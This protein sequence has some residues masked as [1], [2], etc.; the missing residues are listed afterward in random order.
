M[1]EYS[2]ELVKEEL[3]NLKNL[4]SKAESIFAL[5]AT[6]FYQGFHL[7]PDISFVTTAMVFEEISHIQSKLS[8]L[9]SLMLNNRIKIVEPSKNTIKLVQ[10]AAKHMG[11][12][13][14]TAADIS[15]IALAKDKH[16]ILVTDDFAICN[17]ANTMSIALLNLG[18]QG[19]RET[20]KWIKFCKTCA[21]G[22]PPTQVICSLCGNKLRVRYKK[23]FNSKIIQNQN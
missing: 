13:R 15:I 21:R 4:D 23:L 16:A 1:T 11:E 19:I 5:D 20:R 8:I 6:A 18:T 12:S 22:Y 3:D 17:L 14:L 10:S 9:E 2:C 7:H